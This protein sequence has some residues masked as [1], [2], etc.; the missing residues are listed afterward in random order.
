MG[1]DRFPGAPCGSGAV[2]GVST[3]ETLACEDTCSPSACCVL[4]FS[5]LHTGKRWFIICPVAEHPAAD[6]PEPSPPLPVSSLKPE[7]SQG[8]NP[9]GPHPAC[10]LGTQQAPGMPS[11]AVQ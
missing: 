10:S 1:T 3:P 5:V 2:A 6:V 4:C 11:G 8:R 7:V 9:R